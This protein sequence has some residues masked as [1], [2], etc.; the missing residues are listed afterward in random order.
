MS[1]S[2]SAKKV[3]EI[4][5]GFFTSKPEEFLESTGSTFTDFE[6]PN[7]GDVMRILKFLR[8]IYEPLIASGELELLS[9]SALDT[10]FTQIQNVKNTYVN[11]TKS[12][13]QSS[14]QNFALA[15]DGLAHHTH[16]FGLPYLTFGGTQLEA[17]R[18]ALSDELN[19]LTKNNEEVE[20]LKQDVRTL[21]TPAIAGSLSA[22]FHKRRD[23]LYAGRMIW[24]VACL[25][26][27]IYATYATFDFVHSVTDTITLA[28]KPDTQAVFPSIWVIIAIRTVALLPL[29]A[30]FSFA[31]SQYRK[32]RDFEEEYAH[33]A[34]VANSLPNY[35][36]LAREQGVR[37]KI[38]TAATSVIF[39]SPSEQARKTET[40]DVMLGNMRDMVE[41]LSKSF[42]K[43]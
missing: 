23:A 27:G 34:A 3:A 29:F 43:K 16:L 1:L 14:F 11:L 28:Q 35:G 31:F 36:D 5:T 33:K 8:L 19:R 25:L 39:I 42:G 24:L 9:K 4:F 26:L 30:A 12:R 37:D 40:S 7:L 10:L 38:V 17:L 18:Q 41:L 21:I 2:I 20:N 6:G 32:E 15:V 13:D 22:E